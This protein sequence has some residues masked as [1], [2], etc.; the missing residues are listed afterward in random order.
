MSFQNKSSNIFF[1]IYDGKFVQRVQEGTLGAKSRIN[2]IGKEVHEVFHDS[3]TGKIVN[4][5]TTDSPDY[6]KS[7]YFD[8]EGDK[9]KKI[10]SLQ[11]PY[12]NSFATAL[13]KILPNVNLDEVMTLS[14][15]VK[16]IDGKNRSTMFVNQNGNAIKHAY[17]KDAPNGMPDMVEITVKGQKV[18]DDTDRIE[19]LHAMVQRDIL[20]KLNSRNTLSSSHE[21]V[22]ENA[23]VDN[24]HLTIDPD[25]IPFE[26]NRSA[27]EKEFDAMP[28][29]NGTPG[30]DEVDY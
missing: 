2:K 6:G 19:F 16:M 10:Y 20:P 26:D 13:L 8:L 15:S 22:E 24:D 18:W 7:W 23:S 9:D 17:T 3:F 29:S 12:S 14:P 5:R 21:G 27:L 1:T 11:L 25:D 28:S 30:I 4:I